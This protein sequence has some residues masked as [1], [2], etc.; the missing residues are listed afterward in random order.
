MDCLIRLEI[1]HMGPLVKRVKEIHVTWSILEEWCVLC[2][3]SQMK[4]MVVDGR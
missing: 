3:G 2:F 1:D 4:D